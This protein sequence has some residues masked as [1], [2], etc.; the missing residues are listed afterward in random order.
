MIHNLHNNFIEQS[1]TK[2]TTFEPLVRD[3]ESAELLQIGGSLIQNGGEAAPGAAI[4]LDA[5][6]RGYPVRHLQTGPLGRH[7]A[8]R[9]P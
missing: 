1:S 4:L 8:L 9:F 5:V 2:Q 6:E 7:Y 3:H